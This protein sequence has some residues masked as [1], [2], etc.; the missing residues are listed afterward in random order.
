[1]NRS[2]SL[3]SRR[4]RSSSSSQYDN[5]NVSQLDSSDDKDQKE[6]TTICNSGSEESSSFN[7]RVHFNFYGNNVQSLLDD[8]LRV[9]RSKYREFGL[10]NSIIDDEL[11]EYK[12]MLSGRKRPAV[13]NKRDSSATYRHYVIEFAWNEFRSLLRS[14]FIRSGSTLLRSDNKTICSVNIGG[15]TN[16]DHLSAAGGRR[17]NVPTSHT[18]YSLRTTTIGQLGIIDSLTNEKEHKTSFL[19]FSPSSSKYVP[20]SKS[21]DN[22]DKTI[23]FILQATAINHAMLEQVIKELDQEVVINNSLIQRVQTEEIRQSKLLRQNREKEV[24][25]NEFLNIFR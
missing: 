1:M 5:S 10:M 22:T 13:V 15:A 8:S 21:N 19:A 12:R 11:K 23:P 24:E 16:N 20:Q 2:S 6:T 4:F 25:Y 9:Y 17:G 7:K 14:R 3:S 18:D